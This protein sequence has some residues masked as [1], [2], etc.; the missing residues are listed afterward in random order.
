MLYYK[1]MRRDLLTILFIPMLSILNVQAAEIVY[2]SSQNVK[3]N[4]PITAFIGNEK[5]HNNFIC[6][7][8]FV[9]RSIDVFV[10]RNSL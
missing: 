3:I 7:I 10:C 9:F 1:V 8:I 4:S 2:P 6:I 5:K